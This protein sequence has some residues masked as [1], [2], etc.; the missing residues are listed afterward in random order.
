MRLF[1]ATLSSIAT[2]VFLSIAPVKSFFAGQT[3]RA[4]GARLLTGRCYNRGNTHRFTVDNEESSTVEEVH[5]SF[6]DMFTRQVVGY[7]LNLPVPEQKEEKVLTPYEVEVAKYQLK[8]EKELEYIQSVHQCEQGLLKLR[9]DAITFS[10]KNGYFFVQAEVAEFQKRKE[11]EQKAR[12]LKNKKEFVEKMLPVV[13]AFR[14]APTLTPGQNEREDSMHKNFGSLCQ[15]IILVFEKYG[16]KEYNS[17]TCSL[18][19]I[20]TLYT[21]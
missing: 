10:G 6:S 18:L 4:A 20:H 15:S 11:R 7:D 16:Y 2:L 9:K 12:V 17:G 3:N 13:D 8:L 21:G 14:A 1:V 19:I 5:Q